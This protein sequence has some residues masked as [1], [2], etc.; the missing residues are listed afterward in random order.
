M[1]NGEIDEIDIDSID[2][3]PENI[4]AIKQHLSMHKKNETENTIFKDFAKKINTQLKNI[5]ENSTP[6]TVKNRLRQ[7]VNKDPFLCVLLSGNNGRDL[8][9]HHTE[10]TSL[11]E[12]RKNR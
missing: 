9:P 12:K 1:E 4:H 2:I 10:R 8:S 5:I 11:Y 3:D 6:D 7:K